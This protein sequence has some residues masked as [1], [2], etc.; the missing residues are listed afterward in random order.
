M[1]KFLFILLLL[2]SARIYAQEVTHYLPDYDRIN[3]EELEETLYPFDPEAEA[4]V[5]CNLGDYRFV[6]SERDNYRGMELLM[7]FRTKIKIYNE[8]GLDYATFEIPYY[9]PPQDPESVT[10]EG[11]TYNLVDGEI[12]RTD[13]PESNIY[14]EKIHDDYYAKK[15]VFPNV[16]VGS[17]VEI[18]Y[19]IRSAHHFNMRPWWFQQKIPVYYSRLCYRATPLFDY[20]IIARGITEFD[21]QDSTSLDYDMHLGRYSYRERDYTYVMKN[22]PAFRDEEFLSNTNDY[23][24]NINFQMAN[25]LSFRSGTMIRVMST[26]PELCKELLH[27]PDFGKYVNASARAAK[28]VLPEIGLEGKSDLEKFE[29]ICDYVKY[30]YV[31]NERISKFTEKDLP[32][33]LKDKTG[34]SANLNLFM[35]GLMQAAGLDACPI[36]FSTHENGIIYKNYPFLQFMNNVAVTVNIDGVNY[37]ADASEPLTRYDELPAQCTN[38]EGL[39][40]RKKD[41]QWVILEQNEESEDFKEIRMKVLPAEGKI[42]A[43]MKQ[44][45][46][47]NAASNK[48]RIYNG[49]IEKLKDE[50]RGNE[51]MSVLEIGT[52]NFQETKEPF[53]VNMKYDIPAGPAGNEPD[54]I[55]FNPLLY[56]APSETPFKQS[57]RTH[58]VNLIFSSVSNF[59]IEIEIP[60]GYGVEYLPAAFIHNSKIMNVIYNPSFEGGK[61]R[62]AAGFAMRDLYEPEEYAEL[63]TAYENMVRAFSEVII[64][65]KE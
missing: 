46:K 22:M 13:L 42:T 4:A 34:N 3:Y 51:G 52:E 37:F 60:E 47:G 29:A 53:I 40:I 12:T 7:E 17:I 14:T 35:A 25:H 8:A 9:Y 55:Y 62:L 18:K 10:I 21:E 64:L 41:Q 43:E 39:T 23:M 61:I 31:C 5:I 45:L 20:A 63:K 11:M 44:T 32:E 2:Y 27:H 24:A 15:V 38:V 56:L 48:R 6:Y 59:Q 33:F 26:W 19:T 28:T 36:A 54:K 65:K 50:Y 1:K 58:Q 30:K 49:N 16:R 57:L